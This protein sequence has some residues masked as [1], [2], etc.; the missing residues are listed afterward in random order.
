MK[1][2]DSKTITVDLSLTEYESLKTIS[3][4]CQ[5]SVT[6]LIRDMITISIGIDIISDRLK[7]INNTLK[8]N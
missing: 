2:K 8:E 1:R 4:V 5:T 3:A 7:E 6:R